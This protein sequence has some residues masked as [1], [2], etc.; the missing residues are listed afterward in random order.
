[1]NHRLLLPPGAGDSLRERLLN[2]AI[3]TAGILYAHS[4]S[5]E[6]GYRLIYRDFLFAPDDAYIFRSAHRVQLHP[7]FLATA[8]KRA[9]TNHWTVLLTHTHPWDGMVN[10]S[11][12]DREGELVFLPA[13]FRRVPG[14]PH[15]RLIFGHRDYDAALFTT[16][17]GNESSLRVYQ[18][19]PIIREVPTL[20]RETGIVASEET[21]FDRQ[22]RMFG[23]AG[24]QILSR[25]RIGIVGLGGLGSIVA[26]ELAHL[27]VNNFVLID[28]D[29]IE[30][31]NLNR[32]VGARQSNIGTPKVS[33]AERFLRE[34]NPNAA[35]LAIVDSVNLNDTAKRLTVCDFIFVCTD[36]HGSR[37]VLNQLSYQFYLPLIDMG[38]RIDRRDE[39]LRITG[40]IQMLGP[41]LSCLVCSNLLDPGT[42]RR[43]LMTDFERQTDPYIV[44]SPEPQPAVISINGTVASFAV[45]MFLSA[46]TGLPLKSRYQIYRGEVGTVRAIANSPVPSCVVCSPAGALGKGDEWDLPGRKQ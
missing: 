17:E 18:L 1:M 13:V 36:S 35:V 22:I 30:E 33:V 21:W 14:V 10:A 12:I 34:I 45:S 27:G 29:T 9:R 3:E 41:G 25:L 23:S 20:N 16:P 31:S 11:D 44:G 26:Q 24:Q 2:S 28:P 6:D 8:L 40:R 7:N 32:V 43:D 15:G 38:V 4:V 5:T 46:V 42:V 37:A 19:G 39:E